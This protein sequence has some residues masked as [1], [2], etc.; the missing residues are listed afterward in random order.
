MRPQRMAAT[1]PFALLIVWVA[2]S[3]LHQGDDVH[4]LGSRLT[5]AT[6]DICIH[7]IELGRLELGVEI[8]HISAVPSQ[9]RHQLIA[10]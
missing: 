8:V 7:G 1:A 9:D 3:S 5:Q 6:L 4:Y 10:Y 2:V